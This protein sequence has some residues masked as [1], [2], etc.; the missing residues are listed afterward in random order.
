MTA[1][2]LPYCARIVRP[3]HDTL[4]FG[5]AD[6]TQARMAADNLRRQLADTAH[7][8][9][10]AMEHGRTPAGAEVIPPLSGG[11]AEIADALA[12]EARVGDAPARFPDV[13]ARLRA[14]FGYEEACEMQRA[15]L[16]LLDMEDEEDEED[17]ETGEAEQLRRQ[18]AELDARL[19]SVYLDRLDLL[20]V[21]AA[22]PA[23]HPR[24][25]LDADGQPGF[26][27]VLFLTDPDVGQMS[28]HIADV[29]LPLVQHVPWADD[30]D[31]Y[32]TWDGSD[33]DAVRAR[34]RELAQRRAVAARLELR[35]AETTQ[36]DADAEETR[37]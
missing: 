29:D 27:T 6:E 32:A 9:H 36:A 22:D 20:A 2:P 31:P 18:A 15:A 34:L 3:G 30:G 21:L 12:Q 16:A 7:I 37:A 19:R 8:P 11:A 28:F 1:E 4:H 14:Q 26:R 10:T 23:L 35:R 13:F 25:A 17:E 24:L 33:K 5:F